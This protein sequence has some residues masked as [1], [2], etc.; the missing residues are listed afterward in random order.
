MFSPDVCHQKLLEIVHREEANVSRILSTKV[1]FKTVKKGLRDRY[2]LQG[3]QH[4]TPFK[5]DAKKWRENRES[6]VSNLESR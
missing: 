3:A 4:F 2:K 5:M 6:L 1:E